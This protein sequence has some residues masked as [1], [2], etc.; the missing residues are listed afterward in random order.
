MIPWLF[1]S[2]VSLITFMANG[3]VDYPLGISLFLGM[4][5]GGYLGAHTA[6]R[7]GEVRVKTIFTIIVILS[8]IKLLFF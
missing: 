8:G 1:L 6:V 7:K 5:V 4:L 2:L 3:I